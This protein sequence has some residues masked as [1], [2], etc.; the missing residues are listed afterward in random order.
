MFLFFSQ[1]PNDSHFD[2]HFTAKP[3]QPCIIQERGSNINDSLLKL[4]ER[5]WKIIVTNSPFMNQ[6]KY[7]CCG[8]GWT[9]AQRVTGEWWFGEVKTFSALV[10]DLLSGEYSSADPKRLQL[11]TKFETPSHP[12]FSR[13]KLFFCTKHSSNSTI[14]VGRGRNH[15][16]CCSMNRIQSNDERGSAVKNEKQP[17]HLTTHHH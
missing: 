15:K 12:T 10:I 14:D 11:P 6:V 7:F 1:A 2:Y 17:S 13:D 3:F 8:D 4:A 5:R 9:A 16:R